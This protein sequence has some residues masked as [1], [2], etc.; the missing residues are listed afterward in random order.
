MSFV[1]T[2]ATRLRYSHDDRPKIK[3]LE[4]LFSTLDTFLDN[5]KMSLESRL[6]EF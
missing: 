3:N 6:K 2:N 4:A 1:T 5:F